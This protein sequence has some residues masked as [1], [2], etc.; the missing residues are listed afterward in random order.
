M[1]LRLGDAVAVTATLYPSWGARPSGGSLHS[2]W[3]TT[4]L[5]AYVQVA[6]YGGGR[7]AVR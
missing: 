1:A 6:V 7:R 2:F 3:G 4:P 5:A